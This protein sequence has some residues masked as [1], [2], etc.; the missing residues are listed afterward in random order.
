[1]RLAWKNLIHNPTRFVVTVLGI[2][3][4]VFLMI[5]QGSLLFGFVSAA[6]RVIDA[7]DSQ[8][9]LTARGISCFDFAA[10]ISNRI[11]ERAQGTP[12]VA[13][14]GR[15][16]T[17]FAE[18]RKSGGEHSLVSLIGVDPEVGA[19][20]PMP[21]IG[22]TG[23]AVEPNTIVVDQ[24][25]AALLGLPALPT[26]VELNGKRARI[27]DAV[28]GFS[29]F[30]GSPYVFSSYTNA[31]EYLGIP[32]DEPMYVV[33]RL[34]PGFPAE[35]VQRSLQAQMPEVDV[36]TR[37]AFARRS[38]TYWMTQTG[39][40]GGILMAAVLGFLI[41]LV[42]VSQA[43]YATTM[44]NIEEFATLRALGASSVFVI[45]LVL[46]QC[47]IF[48]VLGSAVGVLAALPLV[49]AAK[50]IIAWIYTP[51]ALLLAAVP[52]ALVMCG[53]AGASSIRAALAVEP[54]R[55]FRA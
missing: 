25:S 49:Q 17:G 15:V 32:R 2:A 27:I 1:M 34:K 47:L 6:S 4:A 46:L 20:F 21:R 19:R 48:G 52:A 16:V 22:G 31:A 50:S 11:F 35:R 54:A 14:A 28:T 55:V 24:S 33:L 26:Q 12:G 53:L 36:L 45:R 8:L 43:T 10:R 9:W 13:Y 3:F 39:A 42:V 41:G 7:T 23:S 51:G 30:L 44:E 40:G 38:E 37:D 29:S 18:F 5:F